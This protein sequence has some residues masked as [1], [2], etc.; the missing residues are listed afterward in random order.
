MLSSRGSLGKVLDTVKSNKK[1]QLVLFFG[2]PVRV[3]TNESSLLFKADNCLTLF[4][5]ESIETRSLI[6]TSGAAFLRK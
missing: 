1:I 5:A 3:E 6:S 4:L 2:R